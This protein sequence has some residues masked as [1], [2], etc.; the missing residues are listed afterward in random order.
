MQDKKIFLRGVCKF[1]PKYLNPKFYVIGFM[2]IMFYFQAW[3]FSIGTI[4]ST[5]TISFWCHPDCQS[6]S[7]LGSITSEAM[8]RS[9]QNFSFSFTS[10]SFILSSL[11]LC[12]CNHPLSSLTVLHFFRNPKLTRNNFNRKT[13]KWL[14]ITYVFLS[15]FPLVILKNIKRFTNLQVPLWLYTLN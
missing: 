11:L 5:G 3:S 1:R 6:N 15:S 12:C 4:S 13:K 9:M 2:E 7:R 14:R 8:W 10:C